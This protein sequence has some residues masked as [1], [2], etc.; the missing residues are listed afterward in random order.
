MSQFVQIGLPQAGLSKEQCLSPAELRLRI[1]WLQAVTLAWMVVE[2]G[3]SLAG[4]VAAHSPALLAFG[5][6]SFVELLSAVIVLLQFLPS[7]PLNKRRAAQTTGVLLFLLAA[8]VAVSATLAL[9]RSVHPETSFAGIGITAAALIGMPILARK[10]RAVARATNNHALAADAVQSATCAYL[11]A[12]TL[13]GLAFNAVFHLS[14]VNSGAALVAIPILAER[15]KNK[16]TQEDP[17]RASGRR[18]PCFKRLLR[19]RRH[20]LPVAVPQHALPILAVG[21]VRHVAGYRRAASEFH[22]LHRLLARAHA[23]EQVLE[24][25]FGSLPLLSEGLRLALGLPAGGPDVRQRVVLMRG[26]EAVFGVLRPTFERVGVIFD[27]VVR[28]GRAHV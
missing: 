24:M 27:G 3:V 14:W 19:L 26:G 4:A 6:D 12:V 5:S 7:F 22:V 10:K 17:V 16:E 11:A 1:V 23:L 28:I 2:C 13:L 9:V 15:D 25:V 21:E 20:L 18:K 8:V